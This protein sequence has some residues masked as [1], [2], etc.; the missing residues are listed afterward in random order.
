MRESTWSTREGNFLNIIKGTCEKL[1][2]NV[3]LNNEVLDAFSKTSP[4]QEG[5]LSFLFC[6]VLEIL[7][8]AINKEIN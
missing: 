3:M 6:I 1:T 5:L 4:I 7:A 2:A 8:L